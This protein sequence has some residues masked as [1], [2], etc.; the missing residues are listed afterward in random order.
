MRGEILPVVAARVEMEFM[1]NLSC[2]EHPIEYRRT[3][4]KTKIVIVAT[5]E[6]NP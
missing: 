1:R 5:I 6:I 2:V 3:G 4:F